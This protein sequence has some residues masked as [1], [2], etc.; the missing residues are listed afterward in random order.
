MSIVFEN[1]GKSIEFISLHLT[2]VQ[3]FLT[4]EKYKKRFK[5]K[6]ISKFIMIWFIIAVK[7]WFIIAVKITIN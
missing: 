3:L 1:F 7:I 2:A 5:L 6:K 4:F